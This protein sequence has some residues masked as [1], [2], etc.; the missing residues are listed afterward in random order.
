VIK[1]MNLRV[2]RPRRD[3]EVRVDRTSILGNPYN[4]NKDMP[5]DKSCDQYELWFENQMQHSGAFNAAL[6]ELVDIYEE[7][8]RLN[9]YCWCAPLRCHAETIKHWLERRLG[10]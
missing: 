4:V 7:H 8:G 5:R 10:L 9:L 2:Q 3:H 1:I 6:E